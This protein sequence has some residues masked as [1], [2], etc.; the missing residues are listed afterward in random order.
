MGVSVERVE[1]E[2]T[3]A[4]PVAQENWASLLLFL[5]LGTQ[6]RTHLGPAGLVFLGL[7]Y[8]A[9]EALMRMKGLKGRRK[10]I[11]DLQAMEEAALPVLNGMAPKEEDRPW[12]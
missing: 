5:D 7:D 8:S 9:V 6:W 4:I 10:L 2:G 1:E 12:R 11:A 3:R